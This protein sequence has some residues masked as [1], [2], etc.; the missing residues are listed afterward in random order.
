MSTRPK[1]PRSSRGVTMIELVYAM[2]IMG[3]LGAALL[4][5]AFNGL[6][7]YEATRQQVETLDQTRYA[8]ERIAREIRET[9]FT[10]GTADLSVASSSGLVFTRSTMQAGL[11]GTEQ[12][13]LQQTGTDL[14]LAYASQPLAGA[15]VLLSSVNSLGFTFDTSLQTVRITLEVNTPNGSTLVRETVVQLKNREQT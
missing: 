3:I 14:T 11:E 10:G 4:P 5:M 2:V 9:R 12:V 1:C 8:M 7:A 6:R 15:V 13:T